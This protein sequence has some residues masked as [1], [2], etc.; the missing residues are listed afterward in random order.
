MKE[1]NGQERLRKKDNDKRQTAKEIR[2][3][4]ELERELERWRERER[5]RERQKER[6]GER[7]RE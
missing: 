2:G 6:Q 1:R 7:E 5:E 3:R 4:K